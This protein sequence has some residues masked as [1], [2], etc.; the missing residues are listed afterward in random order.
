MCVLV[1]AEIVRGYWIPLELEFSEAVRCCMW[2]QR[3]RPGATTRT[4]KCSQ[5]LS[6][7]SSPLSSLCACVTMC[8]QVHICAHVCVEA[9]SAS[10]VVPHGLFH[11]S[12]WLTDEAGT[13]PGPASFPCSGIINACQHA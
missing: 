3:T 6:H 2:K 5:P 8:V 9:R 7:L 12:L 1:Q 4:A 13:L 10:G 11:G